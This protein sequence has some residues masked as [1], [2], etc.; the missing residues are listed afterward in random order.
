MRAITFLTLLFFSVTAFAENFSLQSSA[1]SRN[2][3]IDKVYT[4]EGNN[5]SPAIFWKNE[6]A[7][8]KSFALILSDPDAPG[9][10]FYHWILFNIPNTVHALSENIQT[11][12]A[13]TLILKNSFGNAAYNG[14]CPPKGAAHHYVFT[15][16]AL[17]DNLSENIT[18]IKNLSVA[19]HQHTLA[20]IATVGLFR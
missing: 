16:Y 20:K 8:T 14:P 4:C 15:L 5:I 3:K 9:G 10:V 18:S 17:D 7:N 19:I 6:P 13:G 11:L 1:F 2:K 12:P